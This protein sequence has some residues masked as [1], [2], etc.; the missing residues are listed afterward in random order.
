LKE[1]PLCPL[2][3]TSPQPL[4][5][6]EQDISPKGEKGGETDACPERLVVSAR[7]PDGQE[8][9]KAEGKSERGVKNHPNKIVIWYHGVIPN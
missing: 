3:W 1:L 2:P 6:A 8:A 4:C 9:E 5:P 7:L